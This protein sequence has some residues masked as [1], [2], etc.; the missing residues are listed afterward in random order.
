MIRHADLGPCQG[1]TQGRIF[2]E[3]VYAAA[4][5][6]HTLQSGQVYSTGII[7]AETIL[8]DGS[9]SNSVHDIIFDGG[10]GLLETL[11]NQTDCFAPLH[12]DSSLTLLAER[13]RGV[14][15]STNEERG[16][17]NGGAVSHQGKNPVSYGV[18]WCRMLDP[19]GKFRHFDKVCWIFISAGHDRTPERDGH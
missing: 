16:M 3:G 17:Q 19:K 8:R 12:Q 14:V 10:R 9:G 4:E 11:V 2:P 6:D 7:I 13:E 15:N 5:P 1:R 18:E